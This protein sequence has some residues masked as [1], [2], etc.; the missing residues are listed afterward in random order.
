[1]FL[2]SEHFDYEDE[3]ED[4]DDNSGLEHRYRVL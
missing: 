1:L 4:E 3:D 2:P